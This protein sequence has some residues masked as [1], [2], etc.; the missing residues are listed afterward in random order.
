MQ[1]ALFHSRNVIRDKRLLRLDTF[2]VSNQRVK[3][4]KVSFLLLYYRIVLPLELHS[5]TMDCDSISNS[6]AFLFK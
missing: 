4:W 1:R 3:L 5:E 2:Y 6:G